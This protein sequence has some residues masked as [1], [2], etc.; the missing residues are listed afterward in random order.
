M[1]QENLEIARRAY[2]SFT[3]GNLSWLAEF[4]A[5][6]IEIDLTRNVFNPQVIRGYEGIQRWLDEL[7]EVWEDFVLK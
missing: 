5:P 2:E 7:N 4:E 6:E 3:V 1:S